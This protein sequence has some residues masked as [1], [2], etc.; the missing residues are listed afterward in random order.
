[1]PILSPLFFSSG[2]THDPP[3]QGNEVGIHY[4][5]GTH[6]NALDGQ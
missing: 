3:L 5:H 2:E 6:A 4:Q 1:M